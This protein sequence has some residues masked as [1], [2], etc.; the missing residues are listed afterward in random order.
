MKVGLGSP[1][2]NNVPLLPY[3]GIQYSRLAA[4]PVT[5]VAQGEVPTRTRK[6][7][8]KLLGTTIL[9][10]YWPIDQ[11]LASLGIQSIPGWRKS[12]VAQNADK[13]VATVNGAVQTFYNDG[14]NWRRV[15]VGS[16]IANTNVV[17]PSDSLM[18]QTGTV[19]G[20]EGV[21]TQSAP[22]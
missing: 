2:A 7:P 16:P 14:T 13:V 8:V 6:M 17:K 18:L 19:S 4:T 12:P 11:Q 20:G 9:A 5:F 22:Y 10:P 15:S 21:L 1:N 3:H